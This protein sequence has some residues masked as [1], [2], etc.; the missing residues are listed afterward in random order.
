MPA[1]VTDR[2]NGLTTSV[3]VK[4]PCRTVATS[5]ITLSG[6]QTISGYTTVE[7]DRV[8]VIGQS[9]AVENGIYVAGTGSWSR[10]KDC[11]GNLDLVQGTRVIVRSTTIDGVEY[12]L[13]SANPIVIGTTAL[14]F[15]LRYGA[16]ATYDQSV[17]EMSAGVVPVN[18][19]LKPGHVRRYGN[20]L[21]AATI[22]L[23]LN[24]NAGGC[25][26]LSAGE[27][28][29]LSSGTTTISIPANTDIRVDGDGPAII[30]A[31][32]VT[33]TGFGLFTSIGTLG[34]SL[35]GG[36]SGSVTAGALSVTLNSGP[37]VSAGDLLILR[38]SADQS[39]NGD[40]ASYR[41]GEFL[42][43][44]SISGSTVT[45]SSSVIDS[46]SSS[47]TLHKVTPTTT[48]IVGNIEIRGNTADTGNIPTI[49][50][51]YGRGNVID[52]VQLVNTTAT[53]V[54]F[55]D[56]YD[57]EY[58]S[59]PGKYASD[60]GSIQSSGVIAGG[61]N[62]FIHDSVLHASRHG[63]ST[64]GG[65]TVVSRFIKFERC[66]IASRQAAAADFHGCA[67]FCEYRSCKIDGG[68]NLSGARNKIV[69]CDIFPHASVTS[70]INMEANK[71]IDH[72]IEG[73]RFHM[74]GA[75]VR[76]VIDANASTDINAN[77]TE[78]GT[79]VFRNNRILDTTD[80]DQSYIFIRNNGSSASMKM[81]IEGNDVRKTNTSFY[82]NLLSVSVVS[83]SNFAKIT[84]INNTYENAGFGVCSGVDAFKFDG[85]LGYGTV[86]SG[87]PVFGTTT[88][89][90]SMIEL[91]RQ[92]SVAT[93]GTA[94]TLFNPDTAQFVPTMIAGRCDTDITATS[95]DYL[96]VGVAAA[97]RR[98]DFGTFTSAAASSKHSKNSKMLFVNS[99]QLAN[100]A[101]VS[102]EVL[103]L[104]S[105][106]ANTDGAAIANNIGG[107]SQTLTFRI[108]GYIVS[109]M[110]SLA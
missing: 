86:A 47:C 105:V 79:L 56:C 26:Y 72:T 36:L 77:T 29:T 32:A 83:G 49:F 35:G 33:L 60:S 98:V 23:A 55:S 22:Q 94:F 52:G 91:E 18:T 58:V 44:K 27:T 11:D 64:G 67:E 28:H 93:P 65:G 101:V 108:A 1:T 54:E 97:N 45:F 59:T 21:N 104:L 40:N 4:A 69:D 43:V 81:L 3:A 106:D 10:S 13:T 41:Q 82:G 2:L 63:G 34:S 100:Q 17:G 88:I 87:S 24:A 62:G 70:L 39:W 102:G 14:T 103:A 48:K 89:D 12:E 92:I 73:N 99:S 16:N 19:Y 9:N 38:N 75:V 46:Y 37:S 71:S 8:L 95:G 25:I 74:R 7:G 51:K 84:H 31:S 50:L 15:V 66:D 68:V 109:N 30:D 5:N 110:P 57:Y 96:G 80:L 20:T 85:S 76:Y 53:C 78:A 6:L 90:P 42:V 61:Q 107:A